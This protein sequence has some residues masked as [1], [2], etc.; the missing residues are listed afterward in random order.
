MTIIRVFPRKTKATPDDELAFIGMPDLFPPHADEV[1]VSCVFT[2]DIEYAQKIARY[3]G[4]LYDTVKL[5]GPAFGD[6]GDEFTP[7]RYVKH[8]YTMT[9]RGCPNACSFCFVP[10]RE[11]K[12]RLLKIKP[13]W[14]ILDNNLLACPRCHIE[15]VLSML[16][17][18]PKAARFTGGIE[19]ARVEDWFVQQL[20]TM[21]LKQLYMAYDRPSEKPVV[22]RAAKMMV[23]AG[24]KRWQVGCYVLIGHEHDTVLAAIERLEWV[25]SLGITPFAMLYRD[26]TN[27]PHSKE[28]RQ[29]QRTWCRPAAIFRKTTQ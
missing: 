4:K 24:L 27:T 28:W 16:N 13:G 9:S 19:A 18:Q 8:G 14:D 25:K 15:A 21:R 2:W 20:S 10:K 5:G 26:S 3:W 29:L 12:L 22:E 23:D 6:P 17:D 7:G 1:H 11:G